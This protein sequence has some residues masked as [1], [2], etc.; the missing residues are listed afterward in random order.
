M[1][2]TKPRS[3]AVAAIVL[4]AGS[5]TVT[6]VWAK[7]G[8]ADASHGGAGMSG[9]GNAG[10]HMK[11]DRDE[12][13]DSMDE[14]R[15]HPDEEAED[16]RQRGEDEGMRGDDEAEAQGDNRDNENRKADPASKGSD[17]G[18]AQKRENSRAWWNFWD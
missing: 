3:T 9:Q 11:N 12:G 15:K 1:K 4:L 10:E 18:Q 16:S 2:N 5:L 6:P 13:G 8:Q 14:L 17:K 7:P